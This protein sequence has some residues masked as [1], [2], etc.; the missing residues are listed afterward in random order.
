MTNSHLFDLDF[1]ALALRLHGTAAAAAKIRADVST[2]RLDVTVFN[3]TLTRTERAV[4]AAL[5]DG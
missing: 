3:D 4:T 1:S 5:F 2:V